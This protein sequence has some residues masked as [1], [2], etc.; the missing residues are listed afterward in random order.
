VSK[1]AHELGLKVAISGLGGD[2]LFGGYPSFHDIPRWVGLFAV[3]SRVP[4]L[5]KALR[6]AA[7]PLVGAVGG[8]PKSAGLFELGGSYAGA[9]LLRRGLFMPWELDQVLDRDVVEQGLRLLAPLRLIAS[10]LEPRPLSPHAKV[11]ALETSLYMR[12]Q[13]LRDTDWASMAHGL[14]VRVP[15]VDAALLQKVTPAVLAM[16]PS[17]K[18]APKSVLTLS[19]STALPARVVSRDKTGFTTPIAGWLRPGGLQKSRITARRRKVQPT[20]HWSRQWAEWVA[21]A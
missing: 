14:E 9:Y 8:R 3:P 16:A 19:P 7:Q 18:A 21:V 13:L 10:E 17:R 1:A 2:E 6:K 4:F 5:G 20:T 11:A 12:N 15:L